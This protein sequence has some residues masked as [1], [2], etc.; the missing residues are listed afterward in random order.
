MKKF[1][2]LSLILFAV[3]LISFGTWQFFQGNI[4]L[5]LS[6]FPFLLIMFLFVRQLR[7]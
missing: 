1:F 2:A 4:E 7:S 3:I 6:T 5:G